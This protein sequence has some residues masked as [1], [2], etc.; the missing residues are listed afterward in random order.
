MRELWHVTCK[1]CHDAVS[2]LRQEDETYVPPPHKSVSQSLAGPVVQGGL[3]VGDGVTPLGEIAS[4]CHR[5]F[6]AESAGIK[7]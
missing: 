5:R 1:L 7:H 6:A 4:V 2:A 3:G